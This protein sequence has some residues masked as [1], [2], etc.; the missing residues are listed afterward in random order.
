MADNWDGAPQTWSAEAIS[1]AKLNREIRDRM[2]AL[3]ALGNGD[4]SADVDMRHAHKN[5][6]LAARPAAGSAIAGQFYF[7]TDRNTLYIH[8]G[9]AWRHAGGRGAY[10]SFTRANSTTLGNAESGHPWTESSG[11]MEI[12]T[13]SLRAVSVAIATVDT[14]AE[15]ETAKFVVMFTSGS[16]A[17]A[18]DFAIVLRYLDV[19]NFLW[20]EQTSS[21]LNKFRLM[22]TTTAGGTQELTF[23]T[24]NGVASVG[25]SMIVHMNGAIVHA[26][27]MQAQ[28]NV[29][30]IA[31]GSV[32]DL[33]TPF[34]GATKCGVRLA[35][36]GATGD[37]CTEFSVVPNA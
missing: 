3:R 10:D 31:W 33:V 17:T 29:Y 32:A 20:L 22:K 2:D 28:G 4:T 26:E 36:I 30:R 19:N 23:A 21:S 24:H 11:D 9:T 6:T 37:V 16:V 8:D 34:A 15:L 25:H 1:D 27:I 18:L 35:N 7:A 5:G 14:G 13:N 12:A